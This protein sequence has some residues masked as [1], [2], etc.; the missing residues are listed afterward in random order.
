MVKPPSVRRR[1]SARTLSSSTASTRPITRS[2]YGCTSSSYETARR[3][4]SASARSRISYAIVPP[5]VADRFPAEIGER[6][7]APRI[8]VADAQ[9]LPELVV[10][11]RDRHRRAP[12]RRV[13]D[14]AQAD[15]GVAPR[16][17]L[18]DQIEPHVDELGRAVRLPRPG[19]RQSPRRSQRYGRVVPDRP[20]RTARRLRDR[21]PNAARAAGRPL[22]RSQS[23]IRHRQSAIRSPQS[24]IRWAGP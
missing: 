14:P 13:F 18:I 11:Q 24:A 8:G 6:P 19:A 23:A 22:S 5:S 12:H 17:A 21:R 1:R 10:R 15:I 7:E 16:D 20:R 4:C 2:L 3:P 9:H